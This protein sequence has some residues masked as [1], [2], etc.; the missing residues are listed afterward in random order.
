MTRF[1]FFTKTS[2]KEPPRLRHQLARLLSRAGHEV[3][4]F[5]KPWFPW[6][7]R[8][9]APA[10]EGNITFHRH[11]ELLHHKLRLSPLLR[12]ANAFW[13]KREIS[14]FAK[15]LGIGAEDVVVNFNYEYYFLRDVFPG[16]RLVTVINDDFQARPL[17]GNYAPLAE[18]LGLTCRSSDW[19]LTVSHPLQRQL[20]LYCHPR[21]FLPWADC[22]YQPPTP[23]AERN[24]LLFWGF[25]NRRIDYPFVLALA[26]HLL[27][28]RSDI[29][30]LFA[31]PIEDDPGY[32]SLL[33]SKSN[34]ELVPSSSLDRLPM[35]RVLAGFIPYLE[36]FPENDAITFPNKAFQLLARGLPLLIKGMPDFL[37]EPFVFRVERAECGDVIERVRSEFAG[38][39][40]GIED[41]VSRNTAEDRL[42]QFLGLLS[43]KEEL[44]AK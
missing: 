12:Q 28:T 5:E 35:D 32:A 30:M 39:Q 24:I 40:A 43:G 42:E 27:E 34:I 13:V 14:G 1:V 21:L 37:A 33:R 19:V 25:I 29:R 16:N 31:G 36:D 9:A 44:A 7:R 38:L 3:V 26:D 11:Q 23:G 4:F 18:A 41:F 2:W 20:S 22:A 8:P 17:F 15:A 6:R 10:A